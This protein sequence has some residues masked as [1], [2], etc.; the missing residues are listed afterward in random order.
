MAPLMIESFG[1]QDID[2]C[3][4]AP[5]AQSVFLM[6]D[7][8]Q[9]NPTSLPMKRRFDGSWWLQM[10]LEGG[11][12]GYLFVVDGKE[13]LDPNAMC[14]NRPGRKDKVSLIALT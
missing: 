8:N 13:T 11:Y 6:G 10:S 12:H 9:W 3:C 1:A 5:R 7:F 4:P 14:V 2:F